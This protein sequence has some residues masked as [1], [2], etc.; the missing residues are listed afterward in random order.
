[1]SS[2]TLTDEIEAIKSRL[3]EL[4]EIITDLVTPATR[5][6]R[7]ENPNDRITEKQL[8]LILKFPGSNDHVKATFGCDIGDLSKQEASKVIDV[9]KRMEKPP[10]VKDEVPRGMDLDNWG[11]KRCKD[12]Y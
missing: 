10:V 7:I 1:M 11:I 12:P 6:Y 3:K 5:V 4:E 9:L 8:A 2:P